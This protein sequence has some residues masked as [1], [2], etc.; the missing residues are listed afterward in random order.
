MFHVNAP[1][2]M[3]QCFYLDFVKHSVGLVDL[4]NWE[5]EKQNT[6]WKTMLEELW[7]GGCLR[8]F[9]SQRF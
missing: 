9:R 6:S 3:Q 8:T 4:K 5:K 2:L 1:L 7:G